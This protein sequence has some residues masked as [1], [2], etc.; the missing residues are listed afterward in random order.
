MPQGD[1]AGPRTLGAMTGRRAGNCAVGQSRGKVNR[2][3]V[4]GI[5]RVMC[6][7]FNASDLAERSA[8]KTESKHLMQQIH[9]LKRELNE[10]DS[11]LTELKKTD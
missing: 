6:N 5:G 7:W 3:A 8:Q 1:G 9:E 4:R 10:L 11:R 2:G